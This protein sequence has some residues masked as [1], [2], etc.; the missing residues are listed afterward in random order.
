MYAVLEYGA[1]DPDAGRSINVHVNSSTMWEYMSVIG[2][3]WVSS[4][5]IDDADRCINVHVNMSTVGE[6]YESTMRV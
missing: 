1:Q 5:I 2:E 4:Q 6:Y 3:L